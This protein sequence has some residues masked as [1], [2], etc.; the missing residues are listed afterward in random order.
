MKHGHLIRT[1]L[2]PINVMGASLHLQFKG[3][4]GTCGGYGGNSCICVYK[5]FLFYIFLN[6]ENGG[7]SN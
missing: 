2:S 4:F 7:F 5:I 6:N 1:Y 3:I